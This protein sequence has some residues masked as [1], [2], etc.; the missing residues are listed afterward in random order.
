MK[1]FLNPPIADWNQLIKRPSLSYADIESVV[2]EVIEKV[3][4]NGD[5]ALI[6]YALQFDKVSLHSLWVSE[7]EI[8]IAISQVST[9]LKNA[10]TQAFKNINLFHQSQKEE[11]KKIQTLSGV[12]CWR[13][14]KA[15]DKVGLYVPGG[16]APLFSTVLMLGVPASIA[17]CKE[18]IL[19]SPPN[20]KGE[21][22]PAIIYAASLCGI[23]KIFKS[24]GAQAIAAM[25]FGTESIPSV[26][27]IFGPGNPYV[28]AAKQFVQKESLS[29]D[30][31][32]GPS[33]VLLIAD[34]RANPEFVAADLLSQAEHGV[35]SQVILLTNDAKFWDKLQPVLQAQ[36][37]ALPRKNIAEKALDNSKVILFHTWDEIMAFSNLYAPEHLIIQ[38]QNYE[39]LASKVSNAGSV[40]LGDYTP[41]AAGDYAS[42]TNHT[43]PTGGYARAYSGVSLDSF[44]KKITF[45]HISK[46]GIENL[47]D[48]IEIM[49][50]NELLD[51]HKNAVRVRR[52]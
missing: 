26:Y 29:I 8:E 34:E 23:K 50:E 22:H 37:H 20:A 16:T 12:T 43:L 30:M 2:K 49:A 46:T 51:A 9:E 35:D 42:G 4:K 45:Q 15:I 18:I 33:E 17:Q 28:T 40:F 10:I 52:L 36:L 13:E 38:T 27:K 24:G 14:S 5:K 1:Y 44:F 48:T 7:I 19:A 25:A 11:V 3:K 47:G 41:E 6:D 32:A 21:I 39:E 31:P